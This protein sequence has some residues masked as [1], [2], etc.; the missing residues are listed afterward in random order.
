MKIIINNIY[1]YT[2]YSKNQQFQV[3]KNKLILFGE[4]VKLFQSFK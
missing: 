4:T 2:N 3:K 1:F